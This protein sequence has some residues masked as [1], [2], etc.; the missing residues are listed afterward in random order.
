MLHGAVLGRSHRSAAARAR[1]AEVI[2]RSRTL[3]GVPDTWRVGIMAGSDTG[4][5][6]AALWGLLGP[7]PVEVLAW[8]SFGSGW[9]TDIVEQ[10]RIQRTRIH[11]APY[12]ALPD[13]ASV[14]RESDL[15]FVWNGTTSGARLPDADWIAEDRSGLAI[16]DATSAVFAMDLPWERLDAV[17]WSWQKALGGEAQH[18]MLA[19]GPRAVDRLE[20]TPAAA[21]L[22]KLFRL[23]KGG[24]LMEGIFCGDTVNTPSMLCVEDALDALRW[25]ESIGGLAALTA[26]CQANFTAVSDWV[27]RTEW[28]DFLCAD[29]AI[30]SPTSV[31]LSVTDPWFASLP[32]K[33][34]RHTAR[35]M[36]QR[37][38]DEGAAYDID[39]YRSAPPGLRLWAG[40]T[41]ERS[42]LEALFPWLEWAWA[43]QRA[44]SRQAA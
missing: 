39:A 43:Q 17:T 18:G 33:Q 40:P 9:V 8:E 3:L 41:V 13:L 10:L 44:E 35:G 38:E 29:A 37:L 16:C 4:A 25:A 27:A 6:E 34:Q 2:D 20:S 42:D 12:G 32:K 1:L 23:T 22:P 5:F 14:D 21:A 36:T 24:R 28:I 31:C 19:L 30:R 15:V 26:R 7:R 11:R